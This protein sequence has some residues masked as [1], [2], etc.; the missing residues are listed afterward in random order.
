MNKNQFWI[1]IMI[2]SMIMNS[3]TKHIFKLLTYFFFF[4]SAVSMCAH[5]C[6]IFASLVFFS[7]CRTFEKNTHTH[8]HTLGPLTKHILSV[9]RMKSVFLFFCILRLYNLRAFNSSIERRREGKKAHSKRHQT[10]STCAM[11]FALVFVSFFF[12]IHSSRKHFFCF[13]F[14]EFDTFSFLCFRCLCV[15]WPFY[16]LIIIFRSFSFDSN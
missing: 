15:F 2:W 12:L 3:M 8:T 5:A 11:R 14:S 1:H 10:K 6:V 7:I 4:S 13:T 16:F 9:R